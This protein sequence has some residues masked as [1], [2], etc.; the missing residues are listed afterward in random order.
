VTKTCDH[1]GQER[2]A[3]TFARAGYGKFCTLTCEYC[4]D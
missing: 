3:Y 2:F 4:A 1:E